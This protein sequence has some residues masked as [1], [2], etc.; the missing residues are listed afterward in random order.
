MNWQEVCEHP[1]LRDLPFKIEL[2]EHG[3]IIMSPV[4]LYHS[5][6]Q[7]E[8]EF[9]LR[10]LLHTGRTL[11]ECAI[12]TRKGIKVANVAWVSATLW[13]TLKTEAE[14]SHA[15]EICVEILSASN[16]QKEMAEKRLLYFEARAKEVWL[17][18]EN[19]GLSFFNAKH[20]LPHSELVPAFPAKIEI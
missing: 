3:K 19:G 12:K 6:L 13:A 2:D 17:C 20:P 18:D 14:A 11:P 5:A 7:G 8:I 10:S 16:T 1:S 9:L 15:P 4:K